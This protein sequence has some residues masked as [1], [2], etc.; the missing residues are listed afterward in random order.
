MPALQA[1]GLVDVVLVGVVLLSASV[2]ARAERKRAPRMEDV[3][4]PQLVA[5]FGACAICEGTCAQRAG[6][7]HN[8]CVAPQGELRW[9]MP[10]GL[11]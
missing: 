1:E 11:L 10:D 2:R 7:H 8:V 5:R 4:M 3:L 6:I 9:A